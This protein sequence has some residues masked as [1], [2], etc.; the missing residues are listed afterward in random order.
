MARVAEGETGFSLLCRAGSLLCALPLP[1]VIEAM[2]PPRLDALPGMPAFV[3][4]MALVRGAHL[5]VISLTRLFDESDGRSERLVIVRAGERRV[6][7]LVD[8]IVG[9]RAL[10]AETLRQLP[11]LLRDAAEDL[12]ARIG[13]LDDELLVVL[14]A[15]RIVPD[16]VFR[17]VEAEAAAS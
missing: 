12:V 10:S 1:L 8:A 14:K 5:P 2:R 6:G 3:A 7:L 13:T 17:A 15:G 16:E 11:P 9:V 4:G